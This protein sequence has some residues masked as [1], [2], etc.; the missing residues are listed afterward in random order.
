M[1]WHRRPPPSRGAGGGR[2]GP[3]AVLGAGAVP[4]GP[5]DARRPGSDVT[6][7]CRAPPGAG[8]LCRGHRFSS[9]G[10]GSGAGQAQGAMAPTRLLLLVLVALQARRVSGARWRARGLGVRAAVPVASGHP[11]SP[12]DLLWEP[13]GDPTDV[14]GG[15]G[16]PA[17]QPASRADAQGDRVDVGAGRAL[18]ASRL[19]L[20]LELTW[21]RRGPPRAKYRAEMEKSSPR[22]SEVLEGVLKELDKAAHETDQETVENEAFQGGR[23]QAVRVSDAKTGA[24]QST[25]LPVLSKPGNAH[26]ARIYG[27]FRSSPVLSKPG[28]AHRARIY[29]VFRSSPGTEPSGRGP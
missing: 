18:P 3:G 20:A 28:N 10:S 13:Q 27:F 1:G 26:R 15:D 11:N 7:P 12:P 4:Q 24:I 8:G 6:E 5:G 21:H 29:E 19:D 23:S 22:S 14:A 17:S 25:G 16:Y 2:G 9:A